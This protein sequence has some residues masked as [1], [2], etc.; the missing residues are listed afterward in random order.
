[1][2][3]CVCILEVRSLGG[4]TTAVM[5]NLRTY[6]LY[7]VCMITS[8]HTR[9]AAAEEDAVR[10]Q[11]LKPTQSGWSWSRCN[12]GTLAEADAVRKKQ[13]KWT[14][15]G[16]SSVWPCK[17]SVSQRHWLLVQQSRG[18]RHTHADMVKKVRPQKLTYVRSEERTVVRCAVL[19]QTEVR[20]LPTSAPQRAAGARLLT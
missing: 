18:L 4:G 17:T 13:L 14:Q 15:S 3:A 16:H 11:Q 1:M 9:G 20:A 8:R 7:S 5:C 19:T 12:Q 2:C 6:T 10:E